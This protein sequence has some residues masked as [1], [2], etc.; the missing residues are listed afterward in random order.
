MKRN[1]ITGIGIIIFVIGLINVFSWGLGLTERVSARFDE[2]KDYELR[3][4]AYYEKAKDAYSYGRVW[5]TETAQSY[6]LDSFEN[7][8]YDENLNYE[9]VLSLAR[10]LFESRELDFVCWSGDNCSDLPT[11]SKLRENYGVDFGSPD[12]PLNAFRSG[13]VDAFLEYIW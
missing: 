12:M 8:P 2:Y 9:E 3:E 6:E 13:F 7:Y 10:E 11:Y 1:I 4:K 5:G